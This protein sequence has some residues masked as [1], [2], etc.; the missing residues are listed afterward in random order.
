MIHATKSGMEQRRFPM[1]PLAVQREIAA[2]LDRERELVATN[3][4]LI[5]LLGQDRRPPL[6]V[7]G[8][9]L[10]ALRRRRRPWKTPWS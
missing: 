3:R 2:A 8:L 6:S 9:R 5:E 7:C 1:P 10:T 4:T